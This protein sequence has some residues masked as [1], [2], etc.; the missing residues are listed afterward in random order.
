MDDR[1]W[2]AAVLGRDAGHRSDPAVR[3]CLARH[4]S[5][6]RRRRPLVLQRQ[7]AGD[8]RDMGD[9]GGRRP[10]AGSGRGAGPRS[11][12][13]VDR[14]AD[15]GA[16]VHGLAAVEGETIARKILRDDGIAARPRAAA[17]LGE[18][19]AGSTRSTRRACPAWPTDQV[20]LVR[21]CSTS[22]GE[23][24]P[25]FELAFRWLEPTGPRLPA[26]VLVHGDFRLGNMI[27]GHDGLRAVID[28]ELAHSATRWK[29]SAGCA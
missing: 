17:Q 24:H 27:V 5:V 20:E 25:T 12:R 29:T 16:R 1:G 3:W 4:V 2:L 9:R 15:L 19:L 18:A 23:P 21:K 11:R 10:A 7:R 14:A 28:W 13:G 22:S 26:G 6:R 8:V